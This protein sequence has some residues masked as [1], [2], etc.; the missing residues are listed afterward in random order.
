[1]LS[2]ARQDAKAGSGDG[3][4]DWCKGQQRRAM[5]WLSSTAMV[6]Q[7]HRVKS[8][9]C[10]LGGV[11]PCAQIQCSEGGC[12]MVLVKALHSFCLG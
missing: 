1:M 11:W 8:V 2:L 7:T 5:R 9:C 12:C 3:D 6:L 10:S 4:F